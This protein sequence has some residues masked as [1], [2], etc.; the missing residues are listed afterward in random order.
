MIRILTRKINRKELEKIAKEIYGDMVKFAVDIKKEIIA[1]GGQL[2]ADA[3][4]KL[5]RKGSRS[6]DIWGANV[7][8]DH[9]LKKKIEF[10]ALI[11][12]KPGMGNR[13]LDIENP[14][15]RKKIR[16]IVN[17]FIE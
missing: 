11:N 17:K 3:E 7:Y 4:E 9:P 14:K 5:L 13:S 1:L 16:E 2:H 8:L 12:I 6:E 15:V 10:N